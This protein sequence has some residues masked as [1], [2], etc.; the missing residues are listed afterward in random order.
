MLLNQSNQKKSYEENYREVTTRLKL[1]VER[2]QHSRSS[3]DSKQSGK[4]Y[5]IS[6]RGGSSGFYV[7]MD[8]SRPRI[9][10]DSPRI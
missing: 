1:N 8:V 3:S 9:D 4:A 2:V 7:K 6:K 5:H 10:S